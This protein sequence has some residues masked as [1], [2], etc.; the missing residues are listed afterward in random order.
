MRAS[1]S[2]RRVFRLV[3]IKPSHY[4]DD[5]YVIQWVR[6]PIPANSLAC[7]YGLALDAQ[8]RAVLGHDV[9]ID[10]IAIDETNT[11]VRPEALA[12]KIKAAD[13]GMAM[14]VG[15]QSNQ[16]PRC[17]DIAARL[18]AQGITVGIGGFHVSGTLSM[19]PGI[20]VNVQA[21]LDMG[22]F[23][24]AGEAEH[25]RLDEVLKAAAEDRLQPIY[26]HMAD[27]P[28]IQHVPPPHLP[29]SVVRRTFGANT[30]F[31]AGRGCPYQ[32]SF[33]TIINVQ[34]RKSR[35][36]S[37]DDVEAIVRENTR[38]GIFRYF[39]TDDNFAR[40]KDW[41][42]IFDRLIHLREVEG[43]NLRVIIQ[44]DTLCH[45]LPNFIAKAKRAG[46]RR[47]FIGLENISPDNL[48]A[49]KK[50]QNHITDYR[51]MLQ[52]WKQAKV[53]TYCGYIT[54][55][56]NDTPER[57][58]RDIRTVQ[59]E[60]PVDILEFFYLTPLPGSEDHQRLSREGVWMDPDLNKYDLDHPCTV[61][62][63]MGI[64]GWKDIYLKLWRTYYDRPH[65][66][67]V[68]RRAAA[69][70]NS[71]GKTMFLLNWFYGAITIEKIHPLECGLIRLKRRTDRRPTH[72]I[73]NPLTFY[74]RTW[75]EMV[76]KQL[77]WVW[78]WV[79]KWALYYRVKYDPRRLDYMDAALS[80]VT[81]DE[82]DSLE[83]FQSDEAQAYVVQERRLKAVR[84][85]AAAP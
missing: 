52:A 72:R 26:N 15:V 11:R 21:A 41:E 75:T 66:E 45:K 84:A 28:S 47:V 77:R 63:T 64:D 35:R 55:F 59:K 13:F 46:V 6:S 8:A 31:D 49:A 65:I 30:S 19:L 40:N 78:L 62:P 43:I 56:P 70:R 76:A 83:M 4:D 27:L 57:L 22:C 42:A 9:D 34:G 17:L 80:P 67:R 32:C 2:K 82:T 58:L 53:L 61:H 36:R 1:V 18:R 60:L 73:E 5:G 24:F 20:E 33:C 50:K 81:E 38:Q 10:L 7:L 29:A 71:V 3:L 25:G 79:D 44:V 37:P 51:V 48:T 69:T 14:M 39:I 16:F 54:G 68:L 12:A 74:P 85:G 23:V